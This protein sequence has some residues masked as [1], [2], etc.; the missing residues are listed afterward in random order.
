MFY[1]S[2]PANNLAMI[3]RWT[4]TLLLLSLFISFSC[5]QEEITKER[6]GKIEFS[7]LPA[8][9]ISGGRTKALQAILISVK[10]GDGNFVYEH[11]KI[12]LYKFGEEYLS[13]PISLAVGNFSLTEFIVLDE[14]NA[15]LYATPL[16]GSPLAHLVSDP[17]PMPF[18]VSRD[19]T[20]KV[21]P[22]V[23]KVEGATAND[24]GYA[25][26]TPDIV[27]TLTFNVGILAYDTSTSNFE[28]TSANLKI[29]SGGTAWFDRDL[30]AITNEIRIADDMSAYTL[31]VTKSGYQAYQKTF[32]KAELI[33]YGTGNPLVVTLFSNSLSDG[34][35]AYYP[36]SGNAQDAT[37]NNLDG[38]V[39][40]A[41]LTTDR[42]GSASSA[43]IFD[44]VN[45]YIS[46]AD[47]ALLDFA[48]DDDFSISLWAWVDPNQA[49]QVGINDIL[50]KWTGDNQ[51]Y[52]FA[53]AYLSNTAL[54]HQNQFIFA[55]YTGQVCSG[56]PTD[57]SGVIPSG[58][59]N[60]FVVAKSGNQ[61]SLYLNNVLVTTFEDTTVEA[62]LCSTTNDSHMTIGARGQLERFFK[63][64]IDDIRI[65]NRALT[66]SEVASLFAE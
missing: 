26:F 38:V 28:L 51:G 1:I 4:A 32:T 29:T 11:H 37:A 6:T 18:S 23:I 63:G 64:K 52:P 39:S 8:G 46:V 10:D 54:H 47:N 25:T 43:Y 7:L 9:D 65:Y 5:E 55:R 42:H 36:F 16:E 31:H 34:L 53:I 30:A 19:E 41:T 58:V 15:V 59:F 57:Y 13:E 40:G 49:D 17:L 61:I 60:H 50:R 3:N 20:T 33:S 24:F 66:S 44:G 27:T 35:V 62:T 2:L 48:A 12:E 22:Q 45:D 21:S 14:S 56:S